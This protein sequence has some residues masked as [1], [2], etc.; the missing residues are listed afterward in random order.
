MWVYLTAPIGAFVVIVGEL[1]TWVDFDDDNELC[2]YHGKP[3][4]T[5]KELEKWKKRKK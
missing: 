5:G 3:P 1:V 2:D 4:L